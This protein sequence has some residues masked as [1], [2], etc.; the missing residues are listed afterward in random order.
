M[1]GQMN[2]KTFLENYEFPCIGAWDGFHVQAATSLKNYYS[3]KNKYTITSMGLVGC[4]KRFLHLT[5][6]AP[7]STHDARLLRHTALY[8]EISKGMGIPN[9]SLYLGENGF[10][11]LV[12]IGDSAFPSY[13]GSLN[14]TMKIHET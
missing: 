5:T 4:N 2:V 1:N 7:G 11:P 13:H 8:K 6:G 10:I 9:K 3:F 12:T 14:A